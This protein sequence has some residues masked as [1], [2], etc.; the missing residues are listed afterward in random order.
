MTDFTP[1]IIIEKPTVKD[2]LIGAAIGLGATFAMF[3][4]FGL[5][6]KLRMTC[7]HIAEKRRAKKLAKAQALINQETNS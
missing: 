7:L 3:L 4:V 5:A 1:T 2:Q 6:E